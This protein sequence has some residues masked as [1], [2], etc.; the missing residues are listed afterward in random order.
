MPVYTH[1][2]T[3]AI[4]LNLEK[5]A[6]MIAHRVKAA[7]TADFK[8]A[9]SSEDQQSPVL[10][11]SAYVGMVQSLYE[12][13]KN[14]MDAVRAKPDADHQILEVTLLIEKDDETQTV[15]VSFEDN[16][17]GF[18][19]RLF[20]SFSLEKLIPYSDI[21]AGQDSIQSEKQ[22]QAGQ[23]GGQGRGLCEFDQFM[24][25]DPNDPVLGQMMIGNRAEGGARIVAVS[26]FGCDAVNQFDRYNARKI[27]IDRRVSRGSELTAEA[28]EE[29]QVSPL[30]AMSG[31]FAR[32]KSRLT[33]DAADLSTPTTP[34]L[35]SSG[36][37]VST[38]D[39]VDSYFSP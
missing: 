1:R 3:Q 4:D 8:Q 11:S 33:L 6:A 31:L 14:A 34:G 13:M 38:P 16:G 35:S 30:S 20:D 7:W 5:D 21:S 24:K 25:S 9:I 18:C 32:R 27:S 2:Y 28:S 10:L 29:V 12:I 22:G 17:H 23:L 39:S 15:R 26:A 37:E 36:T 19:G